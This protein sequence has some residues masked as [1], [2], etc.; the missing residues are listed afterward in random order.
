MSNKKMHIG[1]LLLLVIM[2]ACNAKQA[3]KPARLAKAA[4]LLGT[5]QQPGTEGM[6]WEIWQKES[7]TIYTGM[8]LLVNA[9]GDTLFSEKLRL[10]DRQDTLWYLP[11]VSNQNEGKEV[12]FKE[13]ALS[14]TEIVFENPLHDF[15]QCIVYRKAGADR[16][17]A[18]IEG[19]QDGKARKEVFSFNR[20]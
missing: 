19:V 6:L 11:T 5:W 14:D 12:A 10:A 3:P 7:D 1:L 16:L 9:N 15:P 13:T 20:K 17:Q 18:S 4:W 8:G 2:G